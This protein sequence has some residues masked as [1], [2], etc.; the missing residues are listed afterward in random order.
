M[1][2]LLPLPV[3]PDNNRYVIRNVLDFNK[4][5][6][7]VCSHEKVLMLDIFRRFL[8]EGYRNP[9]LFSNSI[10]DVHPNARGLGVL[11]R[12]YIDRIHRRYFDPFSP[13]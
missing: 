6:Y 3:T 2:S 13:N 8:F 10:T 12:A 4:L 5:I 7:Q 1:Q 11:A 9:R